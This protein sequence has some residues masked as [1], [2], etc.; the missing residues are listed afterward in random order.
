MHRHLFSSPLSQLL[1]REQ[2]LITFPFS[3][4][5][6]HSQ[7]RPKSN[8]HLSTIQDQLQHRKSLQRSQNGQK[9]LFRLLAQNMHKGSMLRLTLR[10]RY[11][12]A[13]SVQQ[14]GLVLFPCLRSTLQHLHTRNT[15]ETHHSRH[16]MLFILIPGRP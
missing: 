4:P 7:L 5:L 14:V 8:R 6:I 10:H 15:P 9:P 16:G 12:R 2:C 11:L 1:R 3:L 13:F